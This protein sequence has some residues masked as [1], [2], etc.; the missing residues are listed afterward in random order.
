VFIQR[1]ITLFHRLKMN[2][3]YLVRSSTAIIPASVKASNSSLLKFSDPWMID[4]WLQLAFKSQ[5]LVESYE[6]LEIQLF[7]NEFN[8][9]HEFLIGMF[10]SPEEVIFV[11]VERS[12]WYSNLDRKATAEDRMKAMS[13]GRAKDGSTRS[14]WSISAMFLFPGVL[15]PGASAA[16]DIVLVIR[17]PKT[18]DDAAEHFMK[19]KL[20][21]YSRSSYLQRGS[22]KF[23]SSELSE[24]NVPSSP[25]P[26]SP[27]DTRAAAQVPNLMHFSFAAIVAHRTRL[28]CTPQDRTLTGIRTQYCSSLK[29]N[30]RLPNQS[31]FT[32]L[33]ERCPSGLSKHLWELCRRWITRHSLTSITCV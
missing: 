2:F 16:D 25:S 27:S 11:A 24:S 15:F 14:K 18:F 7:K 32:I 23:A 20:P 28:Y 33:R 6:L 29:I 4:S 8:V 13:Q 10:K 26:S 12:A 1:I 22:M 17:G 21:R 3:T 19:K 31:S 9:E 30:S 5:K